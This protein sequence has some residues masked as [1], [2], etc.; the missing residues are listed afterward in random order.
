MV[1]WLPYIKASIGK[2]I[3]AV[4]VHLNQCCWHSGCFALRRRASAELD[5]FVKCLKSAFP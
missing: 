5:E 3:L 4:V 1:D 2:N